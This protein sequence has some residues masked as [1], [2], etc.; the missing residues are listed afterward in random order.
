MKM[1]FYSFWLGTVAVPQNYK[2]AKS[3]RLFQAI[4]Q[5]SWE[6]VPQGHK[7]PGLQRRKAQA[8]S[9]LA[10]HPPT[11][12]PMEE[13]PNLLSP[14]FGVLGPLAWQ[15]P[16]GLSLLAFLPLLS[17]WGREPDVPI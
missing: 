9:W 7:D 2:C 13:K 5:L 6:A 12:T 4:S 8:H 15:W 11:S 14:V 17:L 16:M 3:S 1:S 10:C